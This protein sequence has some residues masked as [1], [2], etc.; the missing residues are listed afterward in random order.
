MLYLRIKK[1][2]TVHYRRAKSAFSGG[3]ATSCVS[4]EDWVIA[5]RF[6]DAFRVR[7]RSRSPTPP[8]SATDNTA[9]SSS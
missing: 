4:A 5:G 3:R 8:A 2:V 7:G 1:Y 6:E 9:S